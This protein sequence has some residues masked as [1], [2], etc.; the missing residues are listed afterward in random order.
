MK[1]FQQHIAEDQRLVILRL[2]LEAQGYDLNS[3]ILQTA[4]AQFGHRPSRDQLHTALT[5]LSEQ[6]LV[7]VHTTA[8]IMVATLTSKG[9]DVAE[10]RAHVPGVKKPSPGE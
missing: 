7:T 6:G 9:A 3:A 5:W 4:L 1:H 10:G 2:L 8:S